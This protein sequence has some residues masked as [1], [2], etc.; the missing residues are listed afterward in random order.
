MNEI[1]YMYVIYDIIL[2]F[3]RVLLE[4]NLNMVFN[5]VIGS[6]IDIFENGKIM[7]VCVKGKI[8]N[9]LMKLLFKG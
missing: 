1:K 6:Y 3:V 8:E 2:V 4:I 5:F 7:W 9:D